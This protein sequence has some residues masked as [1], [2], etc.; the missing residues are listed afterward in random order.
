[1]KPC[2]TFRIGSQMSLSSHQSARMQSDTWLTPPE[3]VRA[4]GSFDLDPC[5]PPAMPWQTAARMV[6]L[7]QD[8]LA[9][10]WEGR[11]WL[12]P[13][14]GNQAHKW[15]AKLSG[16]KNGIALVPARTETRMFFA[17]VWGIADAVLFLRGRPH[18]YYADGT[19][20]AANSG[21]PIMLVAYGENNAEALERCELGYFMRLEQREICGKKYPSCCGCAS[22]NTS[23]CPRLNTGDHDLRSNIVQPL[24]R[25][26]K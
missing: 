3:I 7:P 6:S 4:L 12:N 15:I 18:F 25:G 17:S 24:V 16:H 21:A 26:P 20:A 5:C 19:M 22:L 11:V 1:M 13:P 2:S 14:F 8:G 10:P 9:M 23:D